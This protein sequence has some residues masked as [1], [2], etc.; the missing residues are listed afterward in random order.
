MNLLVCELDNNC[1]THV[2][3]FNSFIFM[4]MNMQSK[5]LQMKNHMTSHGVKFCMHMALNE[6]EA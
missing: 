1:V 3:E 4:H 6:A 5:S 2:C